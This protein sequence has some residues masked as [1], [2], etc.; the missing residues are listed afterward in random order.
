M[1]DYLTPERDYSTLS[2]PDLLA[3]RDQFHV[4]LMHK[5]NVIGTA[6]GRYRIRKGDPWPK[7]VGADAAAPPAYHPHREPRTLANS[8]VRNYSWPAVLVFVRRW[9]PQGAFASGEASTA[10]FIPPAIYMPNGDK[11]PTCVIEAERDRGI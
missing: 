8:E 1:V 10:D 6:V 7:R 3:A 5:A 9:I 4:H 2:L 11:V